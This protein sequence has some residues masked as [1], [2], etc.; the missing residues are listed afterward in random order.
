MGHAR[1][2]LTLPLSKGGEALSSLKPSPLRGEGWVRGRAK[3]RVNLSQHAVSV[4]KNII[5]PKAND[6]I[7][8]TLKPR[9]SLRVAKTIG[10]LPAIEFDNQ[11][12][13]GAEKISDIQ[14]DRHL[15][16][17]FETKKRTIAEIRPQT[18]F[19]VRLIDAQSASIR[20]VSSFHKAPH[21]TLSPTGRGF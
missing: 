19:G 17:K 21:P 6:T 8:L 20:N 12:P 7:A 13:F 2:P 4:G 16:S 10:M 18:F 14:T 9:R 3:R 11:T 15:P 1:H 5:V